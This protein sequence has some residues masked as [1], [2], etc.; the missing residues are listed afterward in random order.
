MT[1]EKIPSVQDT[2]TQQEPP[3]PLPLPPQLPSARPPTIV[4]VIDQLA[5][6]VAI[7]AAFVLCLLGKSSFLDFALFSGSV[8]GIQGAARSVIAKLKPSAGALGIIGI[9]A[10]SALTQSDRA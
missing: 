10:L 7:I 9:I 2:P 4:Q 1:T 8:L 6:I 3:L 5:D